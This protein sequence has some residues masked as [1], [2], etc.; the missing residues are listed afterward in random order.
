VLTI[1]QSSYIETDLYLGN[2]AIKRLGLTEIIEGQDFQIGFH[3]LDLIVALPAPYRAF[4]D[5]NKRRKNQ[6]I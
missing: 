3:S 1:P 6:R 5:A 2:I 4:T